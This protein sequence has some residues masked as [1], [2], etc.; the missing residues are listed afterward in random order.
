M[1]EKMIDQLYEILEQYESIRIAA[2]T[3]DDN[4]KITALKWA[5]FTLEN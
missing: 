3:E 2:R 4:K 1:E 5:I